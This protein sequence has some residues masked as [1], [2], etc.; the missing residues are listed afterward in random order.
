[1]KNEEGDIK[2]NFGTILFVILI[3]LFAFTFAG[4]SNNG[5]SG[6]PYYSLQHDKAPGY[7]SGHS[8]S[9]VFDTPHLPVIAKDCGY[10][11]Y[12]PDFYS[13]NVNHKI[14]EYN[15]KIV[16]KII[17]VQKTRLSIIPSFVWK[18]SFY[19]ASRE[20]EDVSVLS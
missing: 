20:K 17:L 14:S 11:L 18:Y 16:H 15:R 1:M 9:V 5:S 10:S 3:S 4:N 8:D 12:R 7:Y 19:L 13:F 6:S 2:N